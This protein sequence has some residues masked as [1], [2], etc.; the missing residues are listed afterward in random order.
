MENEKTKEE[1]RQEIPQSDVVAL[2]HSLNMP[3]AVKSP[4]DKAKYLFEITNTFHEMYKKTT[5][6]S[7]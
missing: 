4:E 5:H 2:M 3:M 7:S 6:K 1:N